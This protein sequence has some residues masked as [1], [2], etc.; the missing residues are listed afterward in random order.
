MDWQKII[1]QSIALLFPL[2]IVFL[3]I[4]YMLKAFFD[5][6]EKQRKQELLNR[7]S[8]ETIPL[9]LQAYE[10]LTLF[11][12][13]IKP[14]SMVIRVVQPGMTTMGLQRALTDAVREEFEHNLSQQI[15]VSSEAWAM[16]VAARQSM[17]QLITTTAAQNKSE[18]LYIEYATDLLN[19]YA[20]VND[21]PV[22]LALTY[23][24]REAKELL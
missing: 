19:E 4:Y 8:T 22:T 13:R 11:L 23:L 12:E 3:F 5:Q 21:D 16:V 18:D 1:E 24:Q 10:R 15:Y 17:I 14:E 9:K 6:F 7:I 20:S 2:I